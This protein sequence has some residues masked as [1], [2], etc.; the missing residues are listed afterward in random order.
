MTT[1]AAAAVSAAAGLVPPVDEARLEE[2][3]RSL[4]A[5]VSGMR[6]ALKTFTGEARYGAGADPTALPTIPTVSELITLAMA[7]LQRDSSQ[8]RLRRLL[9]REEGPGVV[10]ALVSYIVA[11]LTHA[12]GERTEEGTK[13]AICGLR[14]LVLRSLAQ[15]VTLTCYDDVPDESRAAGLLR[16]TCADV[17]H[18]EFEVHGIPGILVGIAAGARHVPEDIKVAAAECMFI[19]TLRN[20]QGRAELVGNGQAMRQLLRILTEERSPM[21]RNYVAACLR[22]CAQTNAGEVERAGLVGSA[23]QIVL[24]DGSTDVRVL[25]LETLEVIFTGNPDCDVDPQLAETAVSV[26]GHKDTAPEVLDKAC[27]IV[28][29][30]VELEARKCTR[31]LAATPG[32]PLA[33]QPCEFTTRFVAASGVEALLRLVLHTRDP[34]IVAPAA[35]AFRRAVQHAPWRIGVGRR[36]ANN[37][38]NDLVGLLL[39]AAASASPPAGREGAEAE[40]DAFRLVALVELSLGVSLIFAQSADVRGQLVHSLGCT[41]EWAVDA[42]TAILACLDKASPEYFADMSIVD[43]KSGQTLNVLDGVEWDDQGWPT[44]AS[45]F[46]ALNGVLATGPMPPSMQ[47]SMPEVQAMRLSRFTQLL[48]RFSV[49]LAFCDDALPASSPA[50]GPE[51]P[52]PRA[53]ESQPAV[54]PPPPTWSSVGGAASLPRRQPPRNT[55]RSASPQQQ[56]QQQR[57]LS[58]PPPPPPQAAAAAAAASMVPP[59]G[60]RT[61]MQTSPPQHS[62]YADPTPVMRSSKHRS[63]SLSK[64][65]IGFAPPKS[66]R[67]YGTR[68]SSTTYRHRHTGARLPPGP[69]PS[70]RSS[71]PTTTP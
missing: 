37:A 15:L 36:V 17:M 39:A 6:A 34:R 57:S 42:R 41:P 66:M 30:V 62:Y 60:F 25:V 63:S 13:K 47:Y 11:G 5:V 56:Q 8:A 29:A 27:R 64:A 50:A 19:Y 44:N 38:L 12:P 9:S 4:G 54:S 3:L 61:P 40:A 67:R 51:P 21:V 22:E 31:V 26:L 28:D 69:G 45:I 59:E 20:A 32:L 7:V 68:T 33:Q 10:E 71:S 35:R 70:P 52:A 58:Q 43:A 49:H 53:P 65:P 2:E 16:E 14:V 48:L 23:A 55:R 18:A 46:Q 1:A 24:R